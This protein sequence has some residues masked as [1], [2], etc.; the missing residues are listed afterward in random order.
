MLLTSA[1][2][3]ATEGSN[4]PLYSTYS[5]GYIILDH[6]LDAEINKFQSWPCLFLLFPGFS[7]C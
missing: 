3:G 7:P 2:A 6:V 1:D 5:S 4:E